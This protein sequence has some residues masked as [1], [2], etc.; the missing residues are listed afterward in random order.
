MP[1]RANNIPAVVY[2]D[3]LTKILIISFLYYL[4]SGGCY[5]WCALAA[6]DIQAIV[7]L[8]QTSEG[9]ASPAESRGKPVIAHVYR[10]DT[11]RA[12]PGL[13]LAS[14]RSH[15]LLQV[16]LQLLGPLEDG[17]L[18]GLGGEWHAA[19]GHGIRGS[20]GGEIR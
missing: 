10:N 7:E 18:S 5:N 20:Y 16:C 2:L 3:K 11:R 15:Q 19:A 17:D 13:P 4:A 1:K 9:T 12:I 6:T 8:F 14:H